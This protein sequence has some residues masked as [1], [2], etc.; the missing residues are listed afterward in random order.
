MTRRDAV[1]AWADGFGFQMIRRGALVTAAE[2][3]A[4]ANVFRFA[5]RP[6]TQPRRWHIDGA[7]GYHAEFAL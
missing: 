5:T 3:D 7:D 4:M 1:I 6:T 2:V